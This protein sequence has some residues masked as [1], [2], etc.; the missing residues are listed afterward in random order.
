MNELL[1]INK[2]YVL[3]KDIYW[4]NNT[5]IEKI[6]N[7]LNKKRLVIVSGLR[8]IWKLSILKELLIKSKLDNDFFYFNKNLDYNNKIINDEKLEKL[9]N[10]YIELYKKPKIIILE[11]FWKIKWIKNFIPKI[12]KENYKIILIWNNIKISKVKEIEVLKLNNNNIS[13]PNNNTLIQT[14]SYWNL[15]E[16]TRIDKIQIKQ[17]YIN[18][19]KSD[20]YLNEIIQNFWVKNIFL[21]NS[22]ITFIANINYFTSLRELQREIEKVEKISLK[23]LI[24][25][26]NFAIKSKLIKQVYKYDLKKDKVISS[27]S[28]Y[29]FIDTWIRNSYQNFNINKNVLFENYI[30]LE[31][32]KKWYKIFSWKNWKFDFDFIVETSSQPSP[33][34]EKEQEQ[35]EK[36]YFHISKQTEKDEIKKEIKKL[37]K[38]SDDFKKF[39]IISEIE[40]YNFKK[41]EYGNVK[42]IDIKNTEF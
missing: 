18:L 32:L 17:K 34:K 14:L 13:E 8:N 29:Y 19:V 6:V 23:T 36:F 9:L 3:D 41:F 15:P 22:V 1:E 16:V 21:Y 40:K 12:F 33:L 42:L 35:N 31:L 27:K 39:L 30:F 28:K 26:I 11:N 25:Y 4:N 10:E 38:I 37:N 20:I 2:Q 5:I 7:I 24:D